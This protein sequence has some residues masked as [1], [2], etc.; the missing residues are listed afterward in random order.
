MTKVKIKIWTVRDK[1]QDPCG[2]SYCLKGTGGGRELKF[3]PDDK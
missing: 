1:R 3:T 2:Q